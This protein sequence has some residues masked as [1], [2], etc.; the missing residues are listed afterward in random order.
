ME[1]EYGAFGYDDQ[2]RDR[3]HL[4]QLLNKM[5]DLGLS[6]MFFTSD[7]PVGTLDWGAIPGGNITN[8]KIH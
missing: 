4:Q 5:K 8:N 2:P 3:L 7:S 1:N 6:E